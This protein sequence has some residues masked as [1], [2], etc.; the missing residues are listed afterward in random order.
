MAP[1]TFIGLGKEKSEKDISF[2]TCVPDSSLR[3]APN[4]HLNVIEQKAAK[5]S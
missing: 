5:V 3:R 2:R 4:V 1:Q